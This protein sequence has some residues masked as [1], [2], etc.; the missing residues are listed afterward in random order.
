GQGVAGA[1]AEAVA[2]GRFAPNVEAVD[3]QR[4]ADGKLDLRFAV[5]ARMVDI[6]NT[7]MS[8]KRIAIVDLFNDAVFYQ[9]LQVIRKQIRI[10]FRRAKVAKPSD[11]HVHKYVN[12]I[13]LN[14]VINRYRL[15]HF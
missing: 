2:A 5:S 12:Y 15:K 10:Y 4:A 9:S 13:F 8:D 11:F 14:V 7:R 3:A 6:E 1:D